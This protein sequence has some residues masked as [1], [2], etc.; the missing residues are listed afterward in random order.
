MDTTVSSQG[1]RPQV[2]KCIRQFTVLAEFRLTGR[3]EA[4]ILMEEFLLAILG[5]MSFR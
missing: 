5:M 2:T 1:I 4:P 3:N